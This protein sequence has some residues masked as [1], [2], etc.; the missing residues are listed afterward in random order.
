MRMA[1]IVEAV[2]QKRKPALR[3]AFHFLIVTETPVTLNNPDVRVA[4][5]LEVCS[6]LAQDEDEMH[7]CLCRTLSIPKGST[8]AQGV[9]K[10]LESNRMGKAAPSARNR[11]H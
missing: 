8:Y 11:G 9:E 10:V 3:T 2:L 4:L 6:A 7:E 1:D 5:M